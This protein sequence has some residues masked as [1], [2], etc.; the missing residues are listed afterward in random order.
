MIY[1]IYAIIDPDSGDVKYIGQTC[2]FEQRKKAHLSAS[3]NQELRE[4]L[5]MLSVNGKEPTFKILQTTS[6][7]LSDERENYWISYYKKRKHALFNKYKGRPKTGVPTVQKNVTMA[8]VKME[9]PRLK[10]KIKY[11]S[12]SNY[13]NSLIDNDLMGVPTLNA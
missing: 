5:T 1:I 3:H 4:Y 6:V 7:D 11:T 12:F 9:D 2:D 8:V 13:V 10:D